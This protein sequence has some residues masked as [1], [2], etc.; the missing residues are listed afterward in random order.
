M[1]L[2]WIWD[3]LI[4][5]SIAHLGNAAD[6]G[7]WTGLICT[8]ELLDSNFIEAVIYKLSIFNEIAPD[9]TYSQKS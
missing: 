4:R 6:L 3:C 7:T 8:K 9:F 2:F 5:K 1:G